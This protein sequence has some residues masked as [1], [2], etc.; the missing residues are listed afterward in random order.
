MNDSNSTRIRVAVQKSGRLSERSHDLLARCGLN[1]H[2]S[3]NRLF[4]ESDNFSL[5]L[6][7]VRDDDIPEYV[8]DGVCELG[9]VGLNVVEEV[10]LK[11]QDSAAP[12][13]KVLKKLGFGHC[14][15]AIAFPAGRSFEG[16]QSLQGLSIAT[17]YPAT[18]RSFLNCNGIESTIVELT[19][20]VEIAPRLQIADAVCDLVSTGAT[21]KSNGLREVQTVLESECVLVQTGRECSSAKTD[22]IESLFRRI[23]GVIK[24]KLVKY[25]M[26]NAPRSALPAICDILP[27]LE[28]PTVIPLGGDGDKVAIHAVSRENVFW[29]TMEKLKAQGA[30]SILVVPIEKMIE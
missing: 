12:R 7:L 8:S 18:L 28:A 11:R 3:K 16:L 23:Q 29:E 27:G 2:F 10:Q 6:M 15:L 22:I 4:C 26:M 13:M 1:F 14:R 20:S 25:I 21:L 24:A 5:D 9:I 17:S 19:G 30:S